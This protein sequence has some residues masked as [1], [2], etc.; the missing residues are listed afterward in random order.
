MTPEAGPS[1]PGRDP[2]ADALRDRPLRVAFV[3]HS[4]G[5]A[6][7][8]RS[9]LELVGELIADHGVACTVLVPGEGPLRSH[10]EEAGATVL[11]AD[12]PWWCE[13]ATDLSA[14]PRAAAAVGERLTHAA[15]ALLGEPMHAL[16][17]IRPDV[18]VTNTLAVPWGAWLAPV[19]GRPHVWHVCEYDDE[20]SGFRF[21]LGREEL[22]RAI[23]DASSRVF[24]ANHEL[25]ELYATAGAAAHVLYRHIE[26]P[27][28]PY[29]PSGL[30]R[31]PGAIRLVTV[32]TVCRAKG[33]DLV[34]RAVAGLVARGLDLELL[35]VGPTQHPF[36]G[37]VQA[38]VEEHGLA[39]RV[40]LVGRVEDVHPVMAEADA[41]V[42][43]SRSE[44]FGRAPV[45]AMLLGKA[46]VY[47]RT[48]G[49]DEYLRDGE[50]GLGYP[51]GDVEA[52]AD[53][54]ER[55]AADSALRRRLGEAARRD[56]EAT[57]TRERYG[58]AAAELLRDLRGAPPRLAPFW[59]PLLPDILDA[60]R[61]Q[62]LD[63]GAGERAEL[64]A[65]ATA[66]NRERDALAAELRTARAL[67]EARAA[68]SAALRAEIDRFPARV[69]RLRAEA[70]A[71][72]AE[73]ARA[74]QERDAVHASRTWRTALALR[75]PLDLLR[76]AAGRI[77][78][79]AG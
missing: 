51:P 73:A 17:R 19:L 67:R 65:Q 20:D 44:A 30:Y 66:A 36:D 50:T 69:D 79:L 48:G 22:R 75:R 10:L 62:G 15:A 49:P 3:S 78:R 53:A 26:V 40:R 74:R 14:D 29:E 5:L 24:T 64:L 2:R 18:V 28:G 6:G 37:R 13:P 43:G 58:G 4:A 68:E 34:V 76:A 52:L 71:L 21:L 25:A 27:P 70:D 45:E 63:A 54:I 31:R 41:V 77:K 1:A 47:P 35:L 60:A 32:A 11:S 59:A 33:Q 72:R 12:L 8:E 61:R 57:F 7:A 39:D 42:V 46:L 16:R 55:L 9:L 56:A 23:V 38:I